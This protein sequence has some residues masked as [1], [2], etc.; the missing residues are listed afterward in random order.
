MTL[1]VNPANINLS[2]VTEIGIGT[3]LAASSAG[4][5]EPLLMN[6]PM[7]LDLDSTAFAD[8]LS[9]AGATYAGVKAEHVTERMIY[10]AS[11]TAASAAY[12]VNDATSAIANTLA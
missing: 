7:A 6:A 3:E 8:A 9:A 4:T 11:Q 2:A 5:S 10:A 1:N 12:E